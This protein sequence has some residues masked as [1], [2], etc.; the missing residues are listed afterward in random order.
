MSRRAE[1]IWYTAWLVAAVIF[2]IWIGIYLLR[3]HLDS[4]RNARIALQRIAFTQSIRRTLFIYDTNIWVAKLIDNGN[5]YHLSDMKQLT[6]FPQKQCPISPRFSPDGKTIAFMVLGD[7]GHSTIYTIG[8]DGSNLRC[9]APCAASNTS[10][11]FSPDGQTIV[12]AS[13]RNSKVNFGENFKD[14]FGFSIYSINLDGTGLKQLTHSLVND[15]TPTISPD[16]KLIAFVSDIGGKQLLYIMNADGS[17]QRCLGKDG[18]AAPLF[19]QDG[20][21]IYFSTGIKNSTMN[22]I[23]RINIDN[24]NI[25]SLSVQITN[26]CFAFAPYGDRIIYRATDIYSH[27]MKLDGSGQSAK[28]IEKLTTG[29]VPCITG[30]Q[31]ACFPIRESGQHW[32][33]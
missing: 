26:P 16:G 23:K 12:F 3:F 14:I 9:L 2:I 21:Y 18:V 22:T 30:W 13:T 29:Q 32:F 11:S 1:R 17:S 15:Y 33:W 7:R 27:V 25:Q 4:M 10:P 6:S 19:S 8:I 28:S 20:K 31:V 5:S 24:A